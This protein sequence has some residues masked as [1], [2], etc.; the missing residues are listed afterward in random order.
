[1]AATSDELRN[2]FRISAE[3][4]EHLQR[5]GLNPT[6]AIV[7]LVITCGRIF[8]RQAYAETDAPK[9]WHYLTQSRIF[10]DF[11]FDN[12]REAGNIGRPNPNDP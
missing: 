1:M 3:V 5:S 11:G 8:A 4:G 7:C 6:D 9:A 2:L 10:F 12:E